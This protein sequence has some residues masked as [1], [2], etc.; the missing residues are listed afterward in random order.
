[1]ERNNN[2]RTRAVVLEARAANLGTEAMIL[3]MCE[4]TGWLVYHKEDIFLEA[5]ELIVLEASSYP[6]IISSL[7][8]DREIVF[9]VHRSVHNQTN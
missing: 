4:G 5:G 6:V 8:S 9:K 2:H 3:E 1:M 7:D